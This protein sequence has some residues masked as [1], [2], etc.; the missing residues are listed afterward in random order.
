MGNTH[1]KERQE[2]RR[3]IVRLQQDQRNMEMEY[4]RMLERLSQAR[5]DTA[6]RHEEHEIR[7][8]HQINRDKAAYQ[9]L[10]RK[11]KALQEKLG[12]LD[13]PFGKKEYLTKIERRK[14]DPNDGPEVVGMYMNEYKC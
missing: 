14:Y 1:V 6:V 12:E 5:F 9:N 2:Y 11:Y 3:Q 13:G 10:E 8:A 7:S 4:N